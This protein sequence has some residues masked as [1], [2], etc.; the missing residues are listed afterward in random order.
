[1]SSELS[2]IR[3]MLRHL[4]QK[5]VENEAGIVRLECDLLADR[6]RTTR[7]RERHEQAKRQLWTL[8]DKLFAAMLRLI[9]AN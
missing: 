4:E 2:K 9:P 3:E 8:T 6:R 1:M 7:L 5:V